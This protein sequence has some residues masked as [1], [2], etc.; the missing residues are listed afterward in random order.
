[1]VRKRQVA[2]SLSAAVLS[3][4][5]V[6]GVYKLQLRQIRMQE[7]VPVIA[8]KQFIP[9][10]TTLTRDML[11]MLALPRA[12]VSAEMATSLEPLIGMETAAPLGQNEPVLSWKVDRYFLLPK[13]GEATFQIPREYVRSVGSGIR[14]GDRVVLYLSGETEASRRLFAEPVVVAGVKTA[15]NLE[16]DNPKNPNLLS[17]ADGNKERM[18]ASRR[19]ANGTIDSVNLNLTEAQWLDLDSACHGGTAKL[20][21]AFDASSFADEAE[22]GEGLR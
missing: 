18:Y 5:L 20:V 7:S 3:G 2:I 9:A 21:I 14:A 12:A 15:A 1:V 8:P 16:I 10:G 6:Y 22:I 4:L 17:M 13:Q 19:D 11:K